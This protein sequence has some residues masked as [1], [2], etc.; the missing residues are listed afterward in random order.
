MAMPNASA[1]SEARIHEIGRDLFGRVRGEAAGF[2]AGDRLTAGLLAWA[3]TDE[4]AKLQLFRFVDV[5]PALG[6]SAETVRHLRDYL[7]DRPGPFARLT[8]AG[9]VVADL[10]WLGRQAVAGFLRLAVRYLGRRFIAGAT[11]AEA[12][13]A[14]RR[15]RRAGLTATLDLLGEACVSD[16]EAAAY[17]ARYLA[18]VEQLSP[19]ARAWPAQ[20]GLDAAPWGALPRVNVSV[21]L[22]ALSPYFD[23]IDPAGAA[24]TVKTRLRPIFRAAQTHNA[25]IQIDM[26][27]H[28]LKDLTLQVFTELCA[29]PEFR[30]NRNVGIVLQA[31]LLEAEADA[32]RLVEWA[33]QRGAP[34]T[35]RLVKGAYWDYEVARAR[36]EGW[37]IPVY[38]VKSQTDAC[39]E[40]LTRYFLERANT[41]DLVLGSHNIRSIAYAAAC[42][43]AM[44]LPPKSVEYQ[45]LYGMAA[46]LARALSEQGE[47]VRVY[48]PFGELIPGMGYLVRRLL[49]NTSNESFLRRGFADG[50]SP[51]A[52]LAPP[53][54]GAPA[55]A[56]PAPA[57][58]GS[59]RDALPP[60]ANDPRADFALAIERDRFAEALA[61]VRRQFGRFHPLVIGGRSVET[62]DRLASLNPSRPGEVVGWAAS[63]TAADVDEAVAA[64]ERAFPDW[65]DR[66]VRD[67]AQLLHRAAVILRERRTDLAAWIVH[68]AG[69]PWREADGDVIEAIDFL[70]Y[71]GR[72]AMDLQAPRRLG[73]FPG[74]IN[75]YL[76]EPR[77]VVGVIAPWNF[78]LAILTG[79]TAAALATGNTVVMKPARPTPVIA[80]YLVAILEE[81]GLPPGV[82]NY[83]PGPGEVVGDRLARHPAVRMIVFTGSR[84]VGARLYGLAAQTVPGARHLKRVVAEMG[85]KN[86]I[87]VDDDADLDEAVQGI[88]A[89][90]FGYSGQ[91]C[92]ACSRV[93]GV[94]RA[95]DRLLARL[96]EAVRTLPMGA[97]DQPATV[98]GPLIDQAA[99][100]RVQ[101]YIAAGRSGARPALIRDVPADL[102]SLGGYF[103]PPAIFADVPP[104]SPLAQ[105]EI[106]GPVL[107]VMPAKDF[108]AALALAMDSDY[109]LT[110]GVFSRSPTNL[111]RAEEAFRVGDLYINRGITG[112]IVGRQ[113][114]GGRQMSGVGYQAGGPDYLIQFVEGRVIC[115]HTLRRGFASD[116]LARLEG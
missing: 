12:A 96:V 91:K 76:R 113:P 67:R 74:E 98:V 115:E 75:L 48:M 43:E 116:R 82:V 30:S 90:A 72:E 55:E 95:Y 88:V 56:A 65:R 22:S 103:V 84:E 89:S 35:V 24:D 68:E 1:V 71:Y 7:G 11:P 28:R 83:L 80:A 26:E 94:G 57:A 100:R 49:E 27:D 36:L 81:A 64:A 99:Q 47:R 112:A 34:I 110:G 20:A 108:E 92:S 23:P 16:D 15:V 53:Q 18:L 9:L 63:A 45:V 104:A 42:R 10:G 102:G 29:E 44:G 101:H 78:P 41:V 37:P 59:R 61:G 38:A 2:L 73:E 3:M 6:D 109:A 62:P 87:V 13:C 14:V 19:A 17:Q 86:A 40:R 50:E 60:F 46:P 79:M 114:F 39:F 97:A 51:D 8:R 106:F 58:P 4:D 93:I 66:G 77:G 85:G 32:R 52:L 5:L 69:K 70:E 21:K 111:R 54:A 107:S 33:L 31:Y 25:H 105:E